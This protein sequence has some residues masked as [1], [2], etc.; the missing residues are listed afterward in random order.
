MSIVAHGAT[1]NDG[2][3]DSAAIQAAISAA[4]TQ[5]RA[6]FVPAGT[7]HHNDILLFDAVDLVGTGT[8]SVLRATNDE[9][10]NIR[11]QGAG[12]RMS[13]LLLT[14]GS[15]SRGQTLE[16]HRLVIKDATDFIIE[17]VTVDGSRATGIFNYGGSQGVIR[18]NTVRNTKADGIHNTRAASYTTAVARAGPMAPRQRHGAGPL[19]AGGFG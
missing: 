2:T 15:T 9:R 1:A 4:K 8:G 6:V 3:D 16:H 19:K 12:V 5:G 14:S 11:L 18:D 13:D 7:F 17:R 10:H